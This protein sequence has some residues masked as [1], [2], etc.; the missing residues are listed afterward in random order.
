MIEKQPQDGET[1]NTITEKSIPLHKRPVTRLLGALTAGALAGGAITY[2]IANETKSNDQV[3][4]AGVV[5]CP[6]GEPVTG[7]WVEPKDG[8]GRGWARWAPNADQPHQATY[9]KAI[10][11][12]AIS[13]KLSV[14]CGGTPDNWLH[15][16]RSQQIPN[17]PE[18]VTVTCDSSQDV[19]IGACAVAPLNIVPAN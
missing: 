3:A 8:P 6:E 5:V 4:V 10:D 16:D 14:G 19:K 15:D 12:T 13:Y 1:A 9:S 17:T 2:F 7:V 11:Q 18:L